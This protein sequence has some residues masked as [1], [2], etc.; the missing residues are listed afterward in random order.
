MSPAAG[1]TYRRNAN[2]ELASRYRRALSACEAQWRS[3]RDLLASAGEGSLLHERGRHRTI[4]LLGAQQTR[5]AAG[6]VAIVADA[7]DRGDARANS[8]IQ[9]RRRPRLGG[10][11]ASAGKKRSADA[12]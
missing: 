10:S 5:P 6:G 4:G 7:P 11:G 3:A 1:A 9:C 8:R 12:G 2:Y